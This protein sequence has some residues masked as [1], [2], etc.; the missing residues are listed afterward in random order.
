MIKIKKGIGCLLFMFFGL[1]L[2]GS[3]HIIVDVTEQKLYLLE[4][5]EYEFTVIAVY[6]VSTSK[7]G[8]GCA[9]RSYKTPLGLHLICEK[10]GGGGPI[11]TVFVKRQPQELTNICIYETEEEGDFITTRILWLDGIEE[12]NANTRDRFIYIHGTKYEG[13]FCKPMSHGC[14]RMKN[15]DVVD[16]F[17]RVSLGTTVEIIQS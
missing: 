3:P 15:S 4:E 11:G 2:L 12:E 7:F 13:N 10:I 16:L 8:V 14:V 1:R 5:G 6:P 17:D 9:P